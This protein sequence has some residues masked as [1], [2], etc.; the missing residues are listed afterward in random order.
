MYN[1][2]NLVSLDTVLI[3]PEVKNFAETSLMKKKMFYNMK[4]K[5]TKQVFQTL[6][7]LGEKSKAIKLANI[8]KN[9]ARIEK[10]IACLNQGPD[11]DQDEVT[12][13]SLKP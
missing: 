1:L 11:K 6:M 4:I 8:N 12:P 3:P 2:T 7:A 9:I 10:S 13:F 5:S